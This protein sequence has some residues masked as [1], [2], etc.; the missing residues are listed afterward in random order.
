[1]E[2]DTVD[3]DRTRTVRLS[4]PGTVDKPRNN[5][6][7]YSVTTK[8]RASTEGGVGVARV[9]P[10]CELLEIRDGYVMLRIHGSVVKLTETDAR[11]LVDSLAKAL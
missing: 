4:K 3:L 7:A 9:Q 10:G 11:S 8:K 5:S 6:G 1:M 2:R